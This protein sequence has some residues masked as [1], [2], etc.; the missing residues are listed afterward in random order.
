MTVL[1]S[2]NSDSGGHKDEVDPDLENDRTNHS[3]KQRGQGER[4]DPPAIVKEA[5]Y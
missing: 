2:R 4:E 1:Q 3:V 5:G